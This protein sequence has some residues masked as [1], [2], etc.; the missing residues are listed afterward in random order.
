MGRV[1][2]R[3]T[4]NPPPQVHKPTSHAQ[5]ATSHIWRAD[6]D[7]N[8]SGMRCGRL[9]QINVVPVLAGNVLYLRCS[10]S[11]DTAQE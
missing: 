9:T 1:Q 4:P 2:A 5:F 6:L 10:G 8:Q 11:V 3:L 7:R